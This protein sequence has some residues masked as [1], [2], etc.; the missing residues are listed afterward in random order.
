[1]WQRNTT[2]EDQR[3]KDDASDD[4]SYKFLSDDVNPQLDEF[5]N[6]W[7]EELDRKKTILRLNDDCFYKIFSYLQ[8]NDFCALSETC[9]DFQRLSH[10]YVE[11]NSKRFAL[12]RSTFYGRTASEK[13]LSHAKRFI[14]IFGPYLTRLSFRNEEFQDDESP[15]ILLPLLERYC[16]NLQDLTMDITYSDPMAIID[17]GRLCSNLHRLTIGGFVRNYNAIFG[18]IDMDMILMHLVVLKHIDLSSMKWIVRD[19]PYVPKRHQSLESLSLRNSIMPGVDKLTAFLSQNDQLKRIKFSSCF[20]S[21][22]DNFTLILPTLPNLESFWFRF[23]EIKYHLLP[24][25]FDTKLLFLSNISGDMSALKKLSIDLMVFQE[26]NLNS[27]LGRLATHNIIEKIY[28]QNSNKYPHELESHLCALTNLKVLRLHSV[29]GF[30]GEI[31]KKLACGLPNITFVDF[32]YCEVDFT[33]IENFL[34]FSYSVDTINLFTRAPYKQH[35]PLTAVMLSSMIDARLRNRCRSHI[36][37]KLI[38][39]EGI[40]S[41]GIRSDERLCELLEDCSNV[42]QVQKKLVI[43]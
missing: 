31:I 11:A 29:K 14:R 35:S 36:P 23:R 18:S 17:C 34:E 33:M 2:D 42:I 30:N 12:E 10:G 6:E 24:N 19:G 27:I 43:P 26:S 5:L 1:M 9:R 40:I 37:L 4:C 15:V 16:A 39:N 41:D 8:M 25:S 21:D 13:R 20:V 32:S 7:R 22:D 28:I 38:L 3:Q